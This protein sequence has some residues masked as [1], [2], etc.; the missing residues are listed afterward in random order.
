MPASITYLASFEQGDP[1]DESGTFMLRIKLQLV[2]HR[3]VNFL[4]CLS[5]DNLVYMDHQTLISR[6]NKSLTAIS[7]NSGH[8]LKLVRC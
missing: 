1:V 3:F 8:Q 4:I 5:A 7:Y 6:C 2:V